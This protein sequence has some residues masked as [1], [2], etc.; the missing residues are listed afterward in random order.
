M[1]DPKDLDALKSMMESVIDE[2]I[3]KSEQYVLGEVDKRITKSEQHVLEEVDERIE[4][5]EQFVVGEIER[6][7][8]ILERQIE[9]VQENL[10]ELRQYYRITRLES[11]NTALLLRMMDDLTKRIEELERR[12]A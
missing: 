1:L 3:T 8:S 12:T 4:K 7:R 11:D 6:T 2:R 10:D 5:S 9:K